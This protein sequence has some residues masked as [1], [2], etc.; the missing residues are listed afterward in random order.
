MFSSAALKNLMLV[1]VEIE[2]QL[3][4]RIG[5]MIFHKNMV[6]KLETDNIGLVFFSYRLKYL[7][8]KW[9]SVEF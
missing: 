9:K 8:W 5:S 3:G 7:A 1:D 6:T 4:I 2:M